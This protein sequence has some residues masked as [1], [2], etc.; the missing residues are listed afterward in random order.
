MTSLADGEYDF[1]GRRLG[2]GQSWATA[3]RRYQ[4]GF[5]T[6][7]VLAAIASVG[8]ALWWGMAQVPDF[9]ERELQSDVD[10]QARREAAK[11]FVQATLR[12]AE[13]IEHSDSWTEKFTEDQINGWL[14]ED[15]EQKFAQFLPEGVSDPR[16]Q[17]AGGVIHVAFRLEHEGWEGVVSGKLEPWVPEANQLAFTVR[18][19]RAGMV[20]IPLQD[21][22]DE[23]SGQFE[24]EGWL[25]EWAEADGHDAF[26]LHLDP[27]EEHDAV[28]RAISVIDGAVRV[29]G[30][31][32]A[33]Q[34]G[35]E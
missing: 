9:Y 8:A 35:G 14:A 16:I 1:S 27:Y 2:D 18:S 15:L 32:R 5:A 30:D 10:R 28:L 12:L 11:K 22:L 7:L 3:M 26:I 19:I 17:L 13:G 4:L 20:P 23:L 34:D 6:F 25:V 31:S 33:E 24:I 29:S 21:L